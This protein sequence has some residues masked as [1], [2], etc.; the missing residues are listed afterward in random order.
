MT[1]K[2]ARVAFYNDPRLRGIFYQIVLLLAVL[3][4]GYEFVA[5]A[6]DN[7]RASGIATG[8]AFLDYTAGFSINQTL[9]PYTESDTYGRVFWVGLLNTLLVAV[10]GIALAT[11]L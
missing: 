4:L 5:N 9:I 7:L 6:R 3:W 2:T 8:F 10:I 11:V 1:T